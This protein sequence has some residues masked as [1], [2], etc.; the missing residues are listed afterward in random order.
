MQVA[1]GDVVSS[2]SV[3]NLQSLLSSLSI[4]QSHETAL[5]ESLAELLSNR[6]RI[7][8]TLARIHELEPKISSLYEDA[9]ILARNISTTSDIAERIGGKVWSLDEEMKRVKEAGDRVGLVTELKTSLNS[10]QDAMQSGDWESATRHCARAMSIPVDVIS[11]AFAELTIPTAESPLSPVQTLQNAREHLLSVFRTEFQRATESKDA[12]AIS[13]YFK[14]FPVIGWEEEGLEIYSSFVVHLV[15]ARVPASVKTSSP[16]YYITTITSLFEGVALIIDQH[17]PIVE[18][19]YG[20]GKMI[21][22]IAKLLEECDRVVRKL[23]IGWE[24]ERAVKRKL[25]LASSSTFAFVAPTIR[26]STVPSQVPESN[27]DPREIDQILLEI[28]G[29]ASRWGLF[30]RFLY[31]RI[32][33]DSD[34]ADSRIDWEGDNQ[35]NTLA[36]KLPKTPSVLSLIQE[37]A[38]GNL[39]ENLLMEYYYPLEIWYLRVITDKAHRLSSSDLTSIPPTSTTP[40]DFFYVLKVILN[41][42][43]STS[44]RNTLH[45]TIQQLKDII[46]R[47]YASVIQ[48]RLEDVYKHTNQGASTAQKEKQDREQKNLFIVYLNDLDISSSHMDRLI[49]DLLKSVT[50]PNNFLSIELEEVRSCIS[51]LLELVPR[52]QSIAKN[53]IEQ[54]FNQLIRPRLRSLMGDIY[55]DTHYQLDGESFATAESQDLIRKRFAKMWE[56]LTDGIKDMLRETNYRMFFNL[57]VDV[58]VRTWEKFLMGMKFTEA[59]FAGC[60]HIIPVLTSCILQL[61]AIRLDHDIRSVLSYLSSQTPF[62]DAREKFQRLQQISTLLNLDIEEDGEE[63]YNNSGI[64]W[65]VT[66][67]EAKA[68]FGLRI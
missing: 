14:L 44:S 26:K 68:A 16:L 57:A 31:D 33:E 28:S 49:K 67:S 47:D 8:D 34:D 50:I 52:F 53:G 5:S 18:K 17:Q 56:S 66:L 36:V 10:L 63:F 43:V 35:D 64:N 39:F 61:G 37:S 6:D 7:V 27:I 58:I 3:T 9:N 13:R 60:T 48:K 45:K 38:T 25:T 2:R 23:L 51:E 24:E 29:M 65:R 30:R 19:Y 62:G 4:L 12:A 11:G 15:R 55:K 54:L 32:K 1:H 41:R 59:C 21:K 20:N 22:V 46:T 40:D 42:L